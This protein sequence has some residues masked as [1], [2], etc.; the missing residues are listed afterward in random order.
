MTKHFHNER[1]I[2][3]IEL[4]A[5]LSI[6]VMII[7]IITTLIINSLNGF[8]Q[9]TRKESVQEQARLLVEHVAST[10]RKQSY[11]SIE[12]TASALEFRNSDDDYVAYVFAD[13][14]ITLHIRNGMSE[15]TMELADSLS[16]MPFQVTPAGTETK[17][18]IFLDF[19]TEDNQRYEYSATMYTKDWSG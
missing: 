10:V 4:L 18:D 2:T 6:A 3:L 17:I 16:E 13:G 19:L 14:T 12:A 1:G 9:L 5:A 15:Q 11:A 8:N 7:T